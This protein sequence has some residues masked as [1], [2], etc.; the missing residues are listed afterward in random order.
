MDRRSFI[1][2][3]SGAVAAIAGAGRFADAD[4]RGPDRMPDYKPTGVALLTDATPA[5]DGFYFPAE[6]QPHQF[7]IMVMPP[8]QN[9]QDYGIPL[10]D[11]RRQWA[12]VAN[13]LSEYEHVLMVVRPQDR[14]IARRML[15]KEIECVEFPVNDGWS[16]DSG[17]IVLVDGKGQRRV[18]GFT[19]N[20]WGA[21]FPP[22]HDDALMKA[23]LS[24]HLGLEMY[25]IDLVL[26]GGAVAVDGEGTVL[27]TEQCLL[28]PNRSTTNGVADRTRIE[29]LL[30]ES[31]GTKKVIWLGKGLEPD[32]ITD[33]HIDGIAA[34]VEPGVV[35]LH[36]TQDRG[37]PN[38]AICQDAKRRLSESTDAKG[39]KLT[40]VELPL[41]ADLSHMNFYIAND[42]V[43]V[44]ITS[45]RAE[46]ERPLAVLR[47]VCANRKV[48]GVD[49]TVLAEGGGGIHCITQQVPRASKPTGMP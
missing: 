14:S 10:D 11:V 13:K 36:T 37:D 1:S 8:P 27:T 19:F 32:P 23:R 42:C 5:A 26:E 24:K 29:K 35:L 12:D 22:Y 47:E 3:A 34:F 33:G 21:K 6:W 31:L 41:D 4:Q 28:N 43:L 38:F 15:N 45:R 7:T 46:N 44:P 20:G 18:A 48:I 25:P 16:R 9:W 49:S 2:I 40:V 39:R 17:P 30:N